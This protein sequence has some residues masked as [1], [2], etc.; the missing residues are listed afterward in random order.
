MKALPINVYRADNR[1]CTNGGISSRFSQLL[2]ICSEGYITVD[3]ENLPENL[4]KLVK[5][6]LFGSDI[7]HIEPYAEAT[8]IGWMFGGNYAATSDYRFGEMTGIYGAIAI[9]DRQETQEQYDMMA[10]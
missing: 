8:E 3:E 9:H 1:D 4:V 2:L 5:R 6:N 10:D 7:Y